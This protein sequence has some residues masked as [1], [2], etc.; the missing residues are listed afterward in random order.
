MRGK[1]MEKRTAVRGSRAAVADNNRV[2]R[3]VTD[4]RAGKSDNGSRSKRT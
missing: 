4:D 2:K 1:G 3:A